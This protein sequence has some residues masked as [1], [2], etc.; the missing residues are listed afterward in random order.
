MDFYLSASSRWGLLLLAVRSARQHMQITV[1]TY[2]VTP[3]PSTTL[4]RAVTYYSLHIL[5][6]EIDEVFISV[7]CSNNTLDTLPGS[8]SLAL[9]AYRSAAQTYYSETVAEG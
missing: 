4:S 1:R 6:T 8:L 9:Y 7:S 2:Y 5:V 3:P